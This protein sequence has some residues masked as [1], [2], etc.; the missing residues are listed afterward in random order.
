[1]T[2]KRYD[3]KKQDLQTSASG[4]ALEYI[5]ST[6][7]KEEGSGLLHTHPFTELF[8]VTKGKGQYR[9]E[10][11]YYTVEAGDLFLLKPSIAHAEISLAANP[12]EYVVVGFSGTNP[13]PELITA[14][15][16]R[17]IHF[18]S[19]SN[20]VQI[21]LSMMLQEVT[22]KRHRYAEVCQHLFDALLIQLVRELSAPLMP[23]DKDAPLRKKAE[24]IKE[25]I[26]KHYLESIS[27]ESLAQ[28][29][30]VSKYYLVHTFE[31]CYKIS[32]MH[33]VQSL[34]LN[35][36]KVLLRTTNIP[37][38]RIASIVG[39]STH[40][41]FA[42][43]FMKFEGITPAEYRNMAQAA[44]QTDEHAAPLSEETSDADNR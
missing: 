25:F 43:R 11:T 35:E 4:A 7:C 31:Q 27:L 41:Y 10:H 37:T 36:A 39:Y 44:L 8:Y 26:E 9:I 20:Q 23:I 19:S 17:V 12:M 16:F 34:R 29:A 38:K 1:M 28:Q 40:A 6:K 15:K 30:Q 32:P 24:Q 5:S 2:T 3:F 22:K 13:I 33:Y 42:Q 21:Y 18:D 14:N